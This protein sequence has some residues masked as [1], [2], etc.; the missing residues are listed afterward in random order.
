MIYN[1]HY[2]KCFPLHSDE[3]KTAG[4]VV[5]VVVTL[6]IAVVAIAITTVLVV[7]RFCVTPPGKY[8]S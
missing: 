6:V 7:F 3:D 5:P 4:W 1:I 8:K 2:K